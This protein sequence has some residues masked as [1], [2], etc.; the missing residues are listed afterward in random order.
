MK[1]QE[2][3]LLKKGLISN[4]MIFYNDKEYVF[5][6]DKPYD[7]DKHEYEVHEVIEAKSRPQ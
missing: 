4:N 2:Q 3:E 6:K 5:D 1:I 7:P